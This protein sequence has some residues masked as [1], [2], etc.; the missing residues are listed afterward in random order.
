M[1]RATTAISISCAARSR[2]PRIGRS[3][4]LRGWR[5]SRND[6]ENA[7]THLLNGT[8]IANIEQSRRDPNHQ[9]HSAT[10]RFAV[11]GHRV[12]L[13][14]GGINASGRQEHG[15]QTITA[16]GEHHAVPEAPDVTALSTLDV[17]GLTQTATK[18]GVEAGRSDYR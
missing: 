17:R 18:N 2:W 15:S 13:A 7:M 4:P 16:D 3:T 1:R 10:M 8:W 14:Y 5:D 12:T 6:E 11:D 9:F